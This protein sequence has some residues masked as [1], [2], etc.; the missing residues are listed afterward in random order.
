[1][2]AV[3]NQS[4]Q[5]GFA[6]GLRLIFQITNHLNI[7]YFSEIKKPCKLQGFLFSLITD[8]KI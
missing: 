6:G 3:Q 2:V 7:L 8:V 1:M 4:F 5:D